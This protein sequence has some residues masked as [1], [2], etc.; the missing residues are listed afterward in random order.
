MEN[1]ITMFSYK[2]AEETKFNCL[3]IGNFFK[4]PRDTQLAN[5]KTYYKNDVC[6]K[7]TN[8]NYINIPKNKAQHVSGTLR[9]QRIIYFKATY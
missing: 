2:N 3:A 6:V 1:T 5:F 9:V 7:I 8:T 4:T